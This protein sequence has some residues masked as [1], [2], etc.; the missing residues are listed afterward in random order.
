MADE[1]QG[2]TPTPSPAPSAAPPAS[3]PSAPAPSPSVPAPSGGTAQASSASAPPAP[4]WR[5]PFKAAGLNLDHFNDDQSAAQ[6]VAQALTR[7]R[8]DTQYATYGRQVADKWDDVQKFLK[9][10]EEQQKAQKEAEKPWHAKFWQ[11][12]EWNQEWQSMVQQDDRG[13]WVPVPGAPPG[14]AAKYSEYRAFRQQQAE[15]LMQNPYA[16]FEE[17]IKHLAQQ[18]AQEQFQKMTAEREAQ[19]FT[20]SWVKDNSDWLFAKDATGQ[21]IQDPV[22]RQ[23]VLSPHGIK[24]KEYVNDAKDR[25]GITSPQGQQEW[26]L[27]KVQLEYAVEELKRLQSASA[28]PP[29]GVPVTPAAPVNPREAANASILKTT[30][31][32]AASAATPASNA[33]P[34]QTQLSLRQRLSKTFK[35]N[36]ITSDDLLIP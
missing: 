21:P 18:V 14:V 12:P 7:S 27:Q 16:F 35:D 22:T 23:N 31:K 13:N 4:S 29:P 32:R 10:Q 25:M 9:Q 33:N 34:P 19:S 1:V 6:Y 26:A 15:K 5:E 11:P 36:G 20:S 2:G 8:D 17:P 30:P 3:P 28:T 24:F